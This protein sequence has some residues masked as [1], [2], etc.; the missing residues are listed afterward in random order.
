MMAKVSVVGSANGK[1]AAIK[2]KWLYSSRVFTKHPIRT[3]LIHLHLLSGALAGQ[4]SLISF[5]FPSPSLIHLS[6]VTLSLILFVYCFMDTPVLPPM[7]G[8]LL[9][10]IHFLPVIP[11]T[12]FFIFWPSHP[13]L[14]L[15]LSSLTHQRPTEKWNAVLR[16]EWRWA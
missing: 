2:I 9:P 14:H 8:F 5:I 15:S 6:S 7:S 12:L 3:Q 1:R 4:T 13:S 16:R 11:F 10:L